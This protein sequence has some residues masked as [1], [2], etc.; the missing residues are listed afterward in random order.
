MQSN[1]ERMEEKHLV[2]YWLVHKTVNN[3]MSG[4]QDNE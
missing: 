2:C 4:A 1:G 3:N